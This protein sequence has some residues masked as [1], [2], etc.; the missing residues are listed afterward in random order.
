MSRFTRRRLALFVLV[1]ALLLGSSL[2]VALAA[3]TLSRVAHRSARALPAA[4]PPQAA[5][6]NGAGVAGNGGSGKFIATPTAPALPDTATA[7]TSRKGV[8]AT[9]IPPARGATLPLPITP[10][11]A[12]DRSAG[13]LDSYGSLRLSF[14]PNVGQS[15]QKVKFLVRA[16]GSTVFLTGSDTVLKLVKPMHNQDRSPSD[17]V[18][19]PT[20]ALSG[21]VLQ[22]HYLVQNQG[23]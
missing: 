3:V 7:M 13:A 18:L 16:A 12:G 14:E 23:T 19:T 15:D 9:P 17:A 22:L 5:Q 10:G 8:A 11:R 4:R 1:P 21:S 20:A 6:P 2:P